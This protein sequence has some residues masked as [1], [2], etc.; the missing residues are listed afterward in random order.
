L[1]LAQ[2]LQEQG[3]WRESLDLLSEAEKGAS[4]SHRQEALVYD[5]LARLNLGHASSLDLGDRIPALADILRTS[6]DGTIRANAGCALAYALADLND[7]NFDPSVLGLLDLVFHDNLNPEATGRLA[8]ARGCLL[9]Q[10]GEYET[11]YE[12]TSA[13]FAD[14]HRKGAA[15][16]TMAELQGG[17]GSIRMRQGRY[18]EAVMHYQEALALA[19][20]LG[21]DTRMSR[22]AGN[23]A[24]CLGRLGRYSEQLQLATTA[25]R[26]IGPEF[27]GFFE[28]Q[29]AYSTA[30]AHAMRQRFDLAVEAIN[31]LEAR[32]VG[33]IPKWI[34]QAWSLW[35]ADILHISK[36]PG[37]AVACAREALERNRFELQ[38]SSFAG[39]FARWVALICV[40]DEKARL[41][42]P[43]LENL[44]DKLSAYDAIDQ[45]EILSA[46]V[47]L[48]SQD[49]RGPVRYVGSLE[50]R[51][52]TLPL[53][54]RSQLSVL[55]SI[56]L[57]APA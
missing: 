20:R 7:R 27:S 56:R 23:L 22:I 49:G 2:S 31:S 9:F 51:L 34:H 6:T 37:E 33:P 57:S 44:L 26:P 48:D 11:G 14:L 18:E 40:L 41:A 3:R 36:R 53:A 17:L 35:K 45:A 12:I 42:W 29:L 5:V 28:V 10:R 47:Y 52:A 54:V 25:P 55:G 19:N 24:V 39:P 50:C 13:A 8:L 16:L 38:S 1:L 21:N 46:A 30:S 4:D 15:N 43:I 32:L